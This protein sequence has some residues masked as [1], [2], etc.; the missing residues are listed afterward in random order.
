M[1]L[2]KFDCFPKQ[3]FDSAE[4]WREDITKVAHYKKQMKSLS[5]L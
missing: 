4:N 3:L 1:G 2:L 5:K